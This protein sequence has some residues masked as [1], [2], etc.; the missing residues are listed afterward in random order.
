[1]VM[2]KQSVG[3]TPVLR[4]ETRHGRPREEDQFFKPSLPGREPD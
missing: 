3:G 1:M 2:E 4:Q